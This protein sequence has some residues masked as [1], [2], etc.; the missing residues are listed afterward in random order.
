MSTTAI[1]NTINVCEKTRSWL[2]HTI[3]DLLLKQNDISEK[4]FAVTLSTQIKENSDLHPEGWY[5][6]PP[7]GIAALFSKSEILIDLNLTP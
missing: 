7:E 6:P 5:T 2:S 4:Q 1:E 3:S